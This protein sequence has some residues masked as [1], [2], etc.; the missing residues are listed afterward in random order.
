MITGSIGSKMFQKTF[1]LSHDGVIK[2]ITRGGGFSCA[3]Y[4]TSVL[5]LNGLIENIHA[6]VESALR[7]MEN[8]GWYLCSRGPFDAFMPGT[9]LLWEPLPASDGEYHKHIGF[10][11]GSEKAVSNHLRSNVP[12][13][14][15]PT[16]GIKRGKPR[17]KIIAAYAHPILFYN[18]PAP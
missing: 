12:R 2:D 5:L 1:M 15:H 17:R 16:F 6:T 18:E 3:K 9:I 11:M 14:H 8:S 7:D 13:E 4:V 10:F